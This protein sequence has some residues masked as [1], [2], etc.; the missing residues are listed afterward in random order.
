M[1]FFLSNNGVHCSVSLVLESKHFMFKL[2]FY[3]FAG[4]FTYPASRALVA[5]L[6][7]AILAILLLSARLIYLCRK[8]TPQIVKPAGSDELDTSSTDAG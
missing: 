4:F 8:S 5:V 3:F 7:L 6:V 1:I 2:V